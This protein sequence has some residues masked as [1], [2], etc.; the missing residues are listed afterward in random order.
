MILAELSENVH[1]PLAPSIRQALTC[2][3]LPET[4]DRDDAASDAD[5]DDPLATPTTS[6]MGT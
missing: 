4:D 5:T 3:G 2:G 6:D 1:L